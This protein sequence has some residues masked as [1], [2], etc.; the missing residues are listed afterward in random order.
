MKWPRL[1]ST[2]PFLF[3]PSVRTNLIIE[4]VSNAGKT[5]WIHSFAVGEGGGQFEEGDVVL[6]WIQWVVSVKKNEKK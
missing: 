6:G 3:Y 4:F 1:L 2:L 5:N